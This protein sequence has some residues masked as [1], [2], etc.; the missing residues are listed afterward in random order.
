MHGHPLDDLRELSAAFDVMEQ[1]GI[2]DNAAFYGL[3]VG[4]DMAFFCVRRIPYSDV[5]GDVS[6]DQ[7]M[8]QIMEPSRDR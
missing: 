4:R 5:N 8:Y 3:D 2:P 1:L 6:K 7:W